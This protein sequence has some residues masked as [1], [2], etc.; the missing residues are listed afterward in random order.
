MTGAEF[1]ENL[2]VAL[3]TLAARKVRSGLTILGI[4]IGVTSV[5]SVASII[6]GLNGYIRARVQTFGSRTFF[7]GRIPFSFRLGRLPENIRLRKYLQPDDAAFL[8]E[9]CPSIAYATAFVNRINFGEQVDE[10]RYGGGT[11]RAVLPARR[12]AGLLSRH[13]AVRGGTGPAHHA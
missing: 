12:G 9:T 11:R 13:P 2:R 10:I 7:V 5:I 3:D 4:V 6:D 8:K 1:G